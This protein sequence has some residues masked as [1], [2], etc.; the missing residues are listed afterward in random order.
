[1]AGIQ[2]S[3]ARTDATHA[4]A[5]GAFALPHRAFAPSGPRAAEPSLPRANLQSAAAKNPSAG[6]LPHMARARDALGRRYDAKE[7]P[8]SDLAARFVYSPLLSTA[9]K[10]VC[11]F[12]VLGLALSIAIVPMIAPEYLAWVLSHIE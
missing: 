7:E 10:V 9:F 2:Y 12:C 1:M 5:T 8:M 4:K 3:T 11:L 6:E